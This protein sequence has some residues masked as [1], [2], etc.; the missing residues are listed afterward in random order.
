MR[1]AAFLAAGAVGALV[2]GCGG[3]DFKNN[4]RPPVPLELTGVIQE[5]KVTVAPNRIGAGP[6][7]ITLSNQTHDAH[8]ITLEGG[9]VRERVGPDNPLVTATIQKTLRP[10]TYEVRA[11]SDVSVPREIQPAVIVVGRQRPNSSNK[12]LLP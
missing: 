9:S 2:A 10:G 1:A 6:V 12:L 7:L 5:A 11:G 8:T 4:P 3:S